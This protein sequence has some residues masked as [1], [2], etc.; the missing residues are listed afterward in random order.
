[1][2]GFGQGW[3]KPGGQPEAI[4]FHCPERSA[5]A[6]WKGTGDLWPPVAFSAPAA[7]SIKTD[8]G[9]GKWVN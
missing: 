7:F 8:D 6:V 5:L 2:Q 3:D 1:M 9:H 4:L